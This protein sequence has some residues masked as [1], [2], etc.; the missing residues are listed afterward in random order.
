MTVTELMDLLWD[1]PTEALDSPLRV[2]DARDS[3]PEP[4]RQEILT[5]TALGPGDYVLTVGRP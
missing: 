5:L 3:S 2:V 1:V 4:I